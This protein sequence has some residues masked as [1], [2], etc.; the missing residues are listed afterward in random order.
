MYEEYLETSLGNFHLKASLSAQE[1]K[2]TVL[3]G[4][5]GGN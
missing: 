3:L 1:G 4:E 2:T 5:S